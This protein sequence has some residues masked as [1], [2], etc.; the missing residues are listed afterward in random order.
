MALS[1][2]NATRI[3]F[4][5]ARYG[6][7]IVGPMSGCDAREEADLR[8]PSAFMARYGSKRQRDAKL[9]RQRL[10]KAA[11]RLFSEHGY[12]GTSGGRIATTAKVNNAM[13]YH[14]FRNKRGIFRA[15]FREVCGRL[16]S[17][18][19]YAVERGYGPTEKL[20]RLIE[21]HFQFLDGNPEYARLLLWVN[22][23]RGQHLGIDAALLTKSAF[24]EQFRLVVESGIRT[25]E[26]NRELDVSQLLIHL[27]GLCS[28]YHSN[29]RSLS[30]A[31]GLDLSSPA[32]KSE[33]LSGAIRL[34]FDGITPRP[35][36][37]RRA[38]PPMKIA[39]SCPPSPSVGS[40]RWA[41]ALAQ[42]G[43]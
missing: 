36:Q 16:D 11:I 35:E 15:A 10:L 38:Y 6:R 37:A 7:G 12:H 39:A 18:R 17:M 28:I 23:D 14:H 33:G 3:P 34:V 24:F 9:T 8:F 32:V 5:E 22:L 27:V 4:C 2:G 26:F 21:C 40:P 31:L 29:Q 20:R 42:A 25:G 13:L 1:R 41:A 19:F 30:H 43:D